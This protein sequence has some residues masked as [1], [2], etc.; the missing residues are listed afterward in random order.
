MHEKCNVQNLEVIYVMLTEKVDTHRIPPDY[1]TSLIKK[2]KKRKCG[3]ILDLS[4]ATSQVCTV[5]HIYAAIMALHTK[6]SQ[7]WLLDRH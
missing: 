3:F 4:E 2:K 5:Q 1:I 6:M 7:L